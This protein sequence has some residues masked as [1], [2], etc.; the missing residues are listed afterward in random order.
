VAAWLREQPG[1]AGLKLGGRARVRVGGVPAE[2]S[3][4]RFDAAESSR[5]GYP[6]RLVPGDVLVSERLARD[7]AVSPGDTVAVGEA[8]LRVA[9]V[10]PGYGEPAGRIVTDVG[11]L[12]ALGI[13]AR[14]DR[15]TVELARGDALARLT[16]GLPERFPGVEMESRGAVRAQALAVFDRTFAIARALT[17]LALT[18]AAVGMYSALTGLRLQQ[19]ATRSLLVAQGFS[20]AEQRRVDLVRAVAAGG[21]AVVLAVPL[22]IVMAWLLCAVINPRGFGWS[23]ALQLPV[24]GW[25]PPL[26]LGLGVALLTGLLPA[27]SETERIHGAR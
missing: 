17:L 14:F 24:A 6:R 13:E 20:A 9:G 10:F 15:M 19:A 2:L 23:V 21:V 16:S 11:S 1:V 5:Y 18:V 7:L 27:P 12:H 25:L 4:G 26:V 8:R 22:G 3:Y